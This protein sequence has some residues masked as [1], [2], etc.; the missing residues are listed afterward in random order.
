MGGE[1]PPLLGAPLPLLLP[2]CRGSP[3]P[4]LIP[5]PLCSCLSP[6]C[7]FCSPFPSVAPSIPRPSPD[8]LSPPF[9]V[10]P[11]P[12]LLLLILPRFAPPSPPSRG[13]SYSRIPLQPK[14]PPSCRSPARG[15]MRCWPQSRGTGCPRQPK[16]PTSPFRRWF[17]PG[18]GRRAPSLLAQN[19]ERM[20]VHGPSPSPL[21]P[22]SRRP[23][24]RY[25]CSSPPP[26]TRF[27]PS[28]RVPLSSCSQPPPPLP[29][30]HS[31][32]DPVPLPPPRPPQI[33][34]PLPSS[35]RVLSTAAAPT[36][37]FSF[38]RRWTCP[39]GSNPWSSSRHCRTGTRAPISCFC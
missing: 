2:P 27:G 8:P 16:R 20:G 28:S 36:L 4:S 31:P 10:S 13:S 18:S 32:S 23:S 33:G 17:W 39:D 3:P 35:P 11:S 29:S 5:P 7:V 14:P 6:R 38:P 24:P 1:A 34:L 22:L 25:R 9:S 37:R 30:P 21:I 12:W 19:G 15:W 26:T